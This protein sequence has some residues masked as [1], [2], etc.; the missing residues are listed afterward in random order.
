MSVQFELG[1][2]HFPLA[3]ISPDGSIKFMWKDIYEM[4]KLWTPLTTDPTLLLCK[5]LAGA[6]E[7]DNA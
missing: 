1:K 3:T 7:P 5:L 6:Q 2:Y 4:A